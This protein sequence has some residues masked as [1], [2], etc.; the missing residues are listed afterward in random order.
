MGCKPVRNKEIDCLRG[1]LILF[2]V[3][4]HSESGKLH[5]IIFLFHMPLFFILSGYLIQK[6]NSGK[7]LFKSEMFW[8]ANTVPYIY[9]YRFCPDSQG[10][11]SRDSIQ[12]ALWRKSDFRGVLVYNL[13]SL[14]PVCTWISNK[15]L[16]G[17]DGKTADVSGGGYSGTRVPSC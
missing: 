5:D 12:D 2:V 17:K 13:F 11:F 14:H 9:G 7:G 6:K 16:F 8:I 10:N 3:I 15:S 4:G 1:I